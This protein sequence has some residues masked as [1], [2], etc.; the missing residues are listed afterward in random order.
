M[1][2]K[3][4]IAK[5]ACAVAL[6]ASATALFAGPVRIDVTARPE[7]AKVIV[8]GETKGVVPLSVLDVGEGAHLLRIEAPGHRFAEE[9]VHLKDGDF[10]R[11][12]YELETEKGLLLLKSDP[13]GANVKLSGISLGTTPLLVTTLNTDKTY[14]FELESLGYQTKKIDVELAGRTPV[15]R[16]EKL[17]LDS[18][19]VE[20]STVP[21]GADVL[22]NGIK[23]GVTPCTIERVPKGYATLVFKLKG[24][25]EEKRE[26][27][28]VP[29][30]RQLVSLSLQGRP[31]KISVISSPENA[32]VMIDDNYAGRTPLTVS[33]I[34]P[35]AHTIKAELPGYAPVFK[36]VVVENGG[37]TTEMFKFESVLGWIEVV[38]MPP[39]AKVTVDGKTM[40]TTSAHRGKREDLSG[41]K[42]D[43]LYLRDI[44]AGEREVTLTMRGY[45]ET[46][47]KVTVTANK[48]SQ[49]AVRLKRIFIPDTEIET[50]NG[51][52]TGVLM[53]SDNPDT[54]RLE[55][56]EGIARDFRKSDVRSIRPID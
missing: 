38:T 36:T 14:T 15:A 37:N 16:V 4:S 6:F 47:R 7:G 13:S 50:V 12:D 2:L 25:E 52:Y 27:R 17:V 11:K 33:P 53:D 19:V 40:G 23:R 21:S 34:R 22:V 20:C 18:G 39:G 3:I 1:N 24:Y 54:Y 8:D 26:L 45:A 44:E 49:L 46:K 41:V 43:T 29:G 5:L 10:L 35:G 51:T 9:V 42:S 32:R 55:V 31:A 56:K 48:G 30:D 28:V